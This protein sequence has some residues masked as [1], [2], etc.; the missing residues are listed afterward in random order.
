MNNKNFFKVFY[1]LLSMYI[2]GYNSVKV[3]RKTGKGQSGRGNPMASL[4]R[5]PPS[6]NEV[7][8]L[9]HQPTKPK[10]VL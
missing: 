6:I 8:N 10:V 7:T 4:D 3:K 1:L 2:K 9:E 5:P